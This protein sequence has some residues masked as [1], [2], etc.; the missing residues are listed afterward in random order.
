MLE[1][2]ARVDRVLEQHAGGD[3]VEPSADSVNSLSRA[4]KGGQTDHAESKR[5]LHGTRP[6]FARLNKQPHMAGIPPMLKHAR[7]SRLRQRRR[8]IEGQKGSN[9]WMA[10]VRRGPNTTALESVLRINRKF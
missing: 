3:A 2:P 8:G 7:A 6:L 4:R 9:L 1:G 10:A 5:L